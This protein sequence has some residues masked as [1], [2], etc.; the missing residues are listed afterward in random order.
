V[1]ADLRDDN[2]LLAR[3][4]RVLF[5]DWNWPFR[6]AAWLD[7]VFFLIQPWGDGHDTE[8]IVR[9]SALL[10]GVPDEQID[11]VLALL[12][13]YFLKQRDLPV[14]STSPWLREHQSFMGEAAWQWLC[15]RRGW[16]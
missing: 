6:G 7:L 4:G 12:S 11:I 9:D 3:D 8:T 2:I 16:V 5:C 13:G 15:H 1:H 10:H 14:P